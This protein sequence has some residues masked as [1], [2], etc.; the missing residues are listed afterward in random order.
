MS[1]QILTCADTIHHVKTFQICSKGLIRFLHF[2]VNFTD[3][4]FERTHKVG[5]FWSEITSNVIDKN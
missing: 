5:M 1:Q 4:M 2:V 3:I